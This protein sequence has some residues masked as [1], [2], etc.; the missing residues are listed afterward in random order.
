MGLLLLCLSV[1]GITVKH[2]PDGSQLVLLPHEDVVILWVDRVQA[3]LTPLAVYNEL[4]AIALTVQ[5]EDT[6]LA[7]IQRGR[8]LHKRRRA[9]GDP[10][11]HGESPETS[12][13]KLVP[14]GIYP[15]GYCSRRDTGTSR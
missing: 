5:N 11:L 4:L 8:G 3:H 13:P 15:A 6:D 2:A 10:R 14:F 12:T 7:V 9:A 1:L